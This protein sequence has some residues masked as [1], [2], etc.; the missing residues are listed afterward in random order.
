[1][2]VCNSRMYF[3]SSLASTNRILDYESRDEGLTPSGTT[4]TI[5]IPDNCECEEDFTCVKCTW[6]TACALVK[7]QVNFGAVSV[8]SDIS[9]LQSEE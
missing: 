6:D 2:R 5:E 9:L 7:L 4:M 3:H 1:M 8:D